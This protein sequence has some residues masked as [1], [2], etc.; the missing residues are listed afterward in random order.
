MMFIILWTGGKARVRRSK[1]ATP[2]FWRGPEKGGGRG[3]GGGSSVVRCCALSVTGSTALFS[4]HKP[5]RNGK[6]DLFGIL[7]TGSVAPSR[8]R[9]IWS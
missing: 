6:M 3:A 8:L 5:N 7:S 1:V 9:L 2:R 4:V